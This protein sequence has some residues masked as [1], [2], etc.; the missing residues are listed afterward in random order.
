MSPSTVKRKKTRP[1]RKRNSVRKRLSY[2]GK[3][4]SPDK[5]KS[6]WKVHGRKAQNLLARLEAVLD[7]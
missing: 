6:S 1:L 5:S 2:S 4:K 3:R 7:K